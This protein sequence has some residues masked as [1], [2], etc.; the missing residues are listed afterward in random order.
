MEQIQDSLMKLTNDISYQVAKPDH[1]RIFSNSPYLIEELKCNIDWTDP[2]DVFSP[3]TVSSN[4]L[5]VI[6]WGETK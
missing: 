1:K 6:D 4:F 3:K 2:C 5:V